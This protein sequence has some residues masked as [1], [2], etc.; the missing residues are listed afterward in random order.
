M[1]VRSRSMYIYVASVVTSTSHFKKTFNRKSYKMKFFIVFMIG[2]CAVSAMPTVDEQVAL[3]RGLGDIVAGWIN[4]A[5]V[6]ALHGAA[7]TV[8]EL[9]AQLTAGVGKTDLSMLINTTPTQYNL[10]FSY[11]WPT[12]STAIGW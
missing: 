7:Q 8:A 9:L 2:L 6:P 11:Q 10:K 1:L 12:R 3:A 4:Q 5:L